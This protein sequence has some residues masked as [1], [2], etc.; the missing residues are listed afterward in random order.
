MDEDEDEDDEDEV[1][2][3]GGKKNFEETSDDE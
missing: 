2:E 1:A 3:K